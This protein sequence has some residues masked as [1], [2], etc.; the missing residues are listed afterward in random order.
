M[1]KEPTTRR[2][3]RRIRRSSRRGGPLPSRSRRRASMQRSWRRRAQRCGTRRQRAHPL[4]AIPGGAAGSRW[5]RPQR[6]PASPSCC[7]S[8]CHARNRCDCPRWRRAPPAPATREMATPAEAPEL[9][10]NEERPSAPPTARHDRPRRTLRNRAE[11][12]SVAA[13]TAAPEPS[14][15]PARSL[16]AR[17]RRSAA[18]LRSQPIATDMAAVAAERPAAPAARGML[19]DLAGPQS[20]DAWVA[21]IVDRHA[22]GDLDAAAT[23]LRAFRASVPGRRFP[24]AGVAARMGG[25]GDAH[26]TAIEP[27]GMSALTCRA[28]DGTGPGSDPARP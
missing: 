14:P 9:H 20:A 2:P 16:R 24:P 5:P 18:S 19:Q 4:P 6:S 8:R 21:R 11:S 22:A 27:P 26:E 1:S 17:S 13:P 23:D 25:V 15:R 7:C 10:D 12:A 28:L 3:R